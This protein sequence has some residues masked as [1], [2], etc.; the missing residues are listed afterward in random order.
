MALCPEEAV[1]SQNALGLETAEPA[2][3][4]PAMKNVDLNEASDF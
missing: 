2:L 3:A 4:Y 1:T